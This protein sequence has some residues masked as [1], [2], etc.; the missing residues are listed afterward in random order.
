L[1]QKKKEIREEKRR[2]QK[3]KKLLT[4]LCVPLLLPKL[5][6][7]KKTIK[8]IELARIEAQAR[9]NAG[10]SHLSILGIFRMVVKEQGPS[11][12]F[13]GVVPRMFLGVWQTLCMVTG[14]KLLQQY[15]EKA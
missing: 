11:G 7:T 6:T 1:R 14:A 5:K 13:K 3:R 8:K 9:A 10:Q 2:Q 15:F 12:L 4:S